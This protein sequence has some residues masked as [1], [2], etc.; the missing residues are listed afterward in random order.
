MFSTYHNRIGITSIR[1]E[2]YFLSILSMYKCQRITH[3]LDIKPLGF[4]LVCERFIG[5]IQ[6]NIHFYNMC[7]EGG[8]FG[9]KQLTKRNENSRHGFIESVREQYFNM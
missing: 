2:F 6:K 1:T 7:Y 3:I 4:Y 9:S 8:S 5:K